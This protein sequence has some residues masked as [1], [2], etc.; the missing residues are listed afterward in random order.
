MTIIPSPEVHQTF[1]TK[2]T[3]YHYE[4]L[5]NYLCIQSNHKKVSNKKLISKTLVLRIKDNI[6]LSN[7]GPNQVNRKLF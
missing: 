1:V 3:I 7:K 6:S 2:D 4:T 5:L